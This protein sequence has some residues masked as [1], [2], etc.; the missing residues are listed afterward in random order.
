MTIK[1]AF[2]QSGT[3]KLTC[4][5]YHRFYD[6]FFQPLYGK[7]VRMLEVGVLGGYALHAWQTAFDA[8]QSTIYGVSWPP[9]DDVWTGD[10]HDNVHILSRDQSDCGQLDEIGRTVGQAPLDLVIDDGSHHPEHQLN[11]LVKLFP[12]LAPCGLYVIEDIETSRR[13]TR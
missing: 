1:T 8:S 11:I 7:P 5:G 3:D 6:Q 4:H 9:A 2:T 13:R 12:L 10:L